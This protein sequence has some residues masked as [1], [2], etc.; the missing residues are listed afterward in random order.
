MKRTVLVPQESRMS[1]LWNARWMTASHSSFAGAREARSFTSSIPIIRPFPRT[2][3][4]TWWRDCSSR[5][6]AMKYSP[7]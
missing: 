1:P 5:S 3:P 7:T 4:I 6:R 2:S